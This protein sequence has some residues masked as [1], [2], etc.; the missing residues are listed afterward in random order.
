MKSN[1]DLQKDVQDA[2]K[3][4]PQ[5]HGAKVGVKAKDGVITLTGTV[6]SYAK[7]LEAENAAKKVSGVKAVATEI[8]INYEDANKKT[9]AEIAG[10]VLKAWKWR[11]EVPEEKIRVKVEHGWVTLEGDLE[12]NYQRET[13][14]EAIRHLPGVMGVT[15]NIKIKSETHDEG[16][17]ETI[18]QG[19]KRNSS[20]NESEIQVEVAG[21]NV[22][23]TGTVNSFYAKDQA[24]QIAW[25]TRAI[26]SVDNELVIEN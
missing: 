3:W 4:E 15:S 9:D 17:K 20:I 1:Q 2:I 10:E 8:A 16:Q 13:A 14:K 24:E 5:L 23:L 19:L 18:E 12:W 6:D 7:K 25:N 21:N 11:W 22:T 26:F